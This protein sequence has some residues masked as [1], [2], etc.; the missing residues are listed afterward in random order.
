MLILTSRYCHLQCTGDKAETWQS[1]RSGEQMSEV[2][3]RKWPS[4]DTVEIPACPA[5]QRCL[6]LGSQPWDGCH[7]SL[8]SS[9]TRS[10]GS[11]WG[12]RIEEFQGNPSDPRLGSRRRTSQASDTACGFL[13]KTTEGS[14]WGGKTHNPTTRGVSRDHLGRQDL[15]C[16]ETPLAASLVAVRNP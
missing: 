4:W 11:T 3:H 5:T 12:D 14:A 16:H 13:G 15:D 10:W 6:L 2:T 9:G 8:P 1:W 7:P